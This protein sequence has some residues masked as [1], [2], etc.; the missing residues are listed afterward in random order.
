MHSAKKRTSPIQWPMWLGQY[1]ENWKP[2]VPEEL[3]RALNNTETPESADRISNA[4]EGQTGLLPE[5]W[6]KGF[7]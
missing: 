6:Q 3:K 7:G 4:A 1:C 2:D 5:R